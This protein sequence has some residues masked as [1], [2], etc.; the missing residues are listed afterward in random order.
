LKDKTVVYVGL[1][2]IDVEIPAPDKPEE[3]FIHYLD[4]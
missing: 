2:D 1:G 3:E 4:I